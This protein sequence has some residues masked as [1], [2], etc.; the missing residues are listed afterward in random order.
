MS[1]K[2]RGRGRPPLSV[3]T[4]KVDLRLPGALLSLAR[5][6]AQ[7]EGVPLSAWIRAAM[8]ARLAEVER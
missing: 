4:T 5:E 6:A 7:R 8:A 1:D 3:D 2:S